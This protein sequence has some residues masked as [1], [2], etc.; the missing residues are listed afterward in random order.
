M[1]ISGSARAVDERDYLVIKLMVVLAMCT[2]LTILTKS[3][4]MLDHSLF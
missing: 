2:E 1:K 4:L 3:K